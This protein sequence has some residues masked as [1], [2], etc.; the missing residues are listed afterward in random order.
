MDYKRTSGLKNFF[1]FTNKEFPTRFKPHKNLPYKKPFNGVGTGISRILPAHRKL[2]FHSHHPRFFVIKN[3][4][5]PF[6]WKMIIHADDF[7]KKKEKNLV[8]QSI[9]R[10]R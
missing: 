7:L 10:A 4:T 9:N 5:N 3:K 2:S 6:R 1:N 8:V